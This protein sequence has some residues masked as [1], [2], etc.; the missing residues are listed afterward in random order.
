MNEEH[1]MDV[2]SDKRGGAAKRR[3]GKAH[4]GHHYQEDSQLDRTDSKQRVLVGTEEKW[5]N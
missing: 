2:Q 3:P 5:T 1:Q 4:F